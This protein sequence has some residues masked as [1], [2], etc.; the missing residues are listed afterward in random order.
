MREEEIA[1]E[2][3]KKKKGKVRN[4]E[5]ERRRWENDTEQDVE[6]PGQEDGSKRKEESRRGEKSQYMSVFQEKTL[7]I[8]VLSGR[9][10]TL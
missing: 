6:E 10:L 5:R 3:E 2:E 1:T 8:Q 7:L 9:Q 4:R